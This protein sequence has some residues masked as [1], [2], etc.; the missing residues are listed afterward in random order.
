KQLTD[1]LDLPV[2]ALPADRRPARHVWHCPV[3][4][5]PGDR[6]LT[7]AEWGEVA[8]RIVH[9]TGIAPEG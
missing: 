5:A 6:L 2:L 1:R 9:A 4:T 7:D 3:R 8:R